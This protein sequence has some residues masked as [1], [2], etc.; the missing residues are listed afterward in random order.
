SCFKKKETND[1]QEIKRDRKSERGAIMNV[2]FYQRFFDR[3]SESWEG[4]SINEFMGFLIPKCR[5]VITVERLRDLLGEKRKLRIKF[6][7]DPTAKDIHLGHIVPIMLLQQFA[8]K[9]HHIDFII[10]DFTARIGDP[11]GR[12]TARKPLAPGIIVENMKTYKDQINKYVDVLDFHFYHNSEWLSSISLEEIFTIFQRINLAEAIQRKDFQKRLR[13]SRAV[14]LA[15]V[16]YGI[17]MGIDSLHLHTDIEVGGIDQLLNFQQ[18]RK[19][20]REEGFSEEVVLMTPVLEGITG[21]G[22]KMSKSY[23][24]YIAV[25]DSIEDKFGKIMSIPDRL[26]FQYFCCFVDIHERELKNL[27]MLIESNPLEAKKQLATF[28]IF[29]ETKNISDALQERE[30]FE[31]KFSQRTI[32]EED[33]IPLPVDSNTEL[34]DVLIATNNFKSRSEIRRLFSQNA[35]RLLENNKELVLTPNDKIDK[36]CIIRVGKRKFFKMIPE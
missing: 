33:C 10:G 28:I 1:K 14:T 34:I 19:I 23:N 36:I 8:K 16:C 35:I 30:K 26:I 31:R 21:D 24:N 15:E 18:C 5:E 2:T 32:L 29:L 25:N 17:L 27:K 7:I 22:K 11:T 20:M 13:T 12:E 4:I 9:G 6:G 3:I